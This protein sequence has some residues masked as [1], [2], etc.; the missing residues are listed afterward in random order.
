MTVTDPL[1]ESLAGWPVA[2]RYAVSRAMIERCAEAREAGDWRAGC[3]AANVDVTVDLRQVARQH[4]PGTAELLADD[5]RHL[6]PD[7]LRWHLPRAAGSLLSPDQVFA[8][9][10]YGPTPDRGPYLMVQTPELAHGSQR[11]RLGFGDLPDRQVG[12]TGGRCQW[13]TASRHLWHIRYT[14]EL[15]ARCGGGERAPFFERDGRPRAVAPPVARPAA[16]DPAAY[17][18]WLTVRYGAVD[19][20]PDACVAVFRAAGMALDLHMPPTDP[21]STSPQR[22]AQALVR[23]HIAVGR[24]AAEAVALRAVSPR[25]VIP[26]YSIDLLLDVS[27]PGTARAKVDA[28]RKYPDSGPESVEVLPESSWRPLPDLDLLRVGRITPDE[29]HPLVCRALFPDHPPAAGP[30]SPPKPE[31]VRV[32]CGGVWHEVRPT[33]GHLTIPHTAAEELREQAITAFGATTMG[34]FATK[35]AW[36]TGTGRLPRRLRPQRQDL[37]WRARHGDTAGV[38]E[39]LYAGMDLAVR[40]GQRLTLLHLLP[41][42]DHEVL[43]P[44]LLAAGLDLD[45]RD[46]L[47]R[48]PMHCAVGND[49]S[50]ALIRA[51]FDAGA[52]ITVV[53]HAGQSVGDLLAGHDRKGELDFLVEASHRQYHRAVGGST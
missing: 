10:S 35:R 50:P 3:A 49:G 7:L 53:D 26:F 33:G 40:D 29:L 6:A 43:L 44:R 41:G 16:D 15:R 27:E 23:E 2:R 22:L 39:L 5:L 13:W 14:D 37:F 20:D 46:D 32:R 8:L 11:L 17:T 18:E 12:G 25:W 47:G 31:P 30:P 45:S 38:V 4:G 1:P 9:A 48:T 52:A 24:L 36:L 21:R 42:L 28:R 51:L 19:S 34:C